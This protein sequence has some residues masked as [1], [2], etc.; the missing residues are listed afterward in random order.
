M[1]DEEIKK[2]LAKAA[3]ADAVKPKVHR[4]H[5]AVTYKK[6]PKLGSTK[7][8]FKEDA[9][10]K[11][12]I[13]GYPV[14]GLDKIASPIPKRSRYGRLMKGA[15]SLHSMSRCV[16]PPLAQMPE[17]MVEENPDLIVSGRRVCAL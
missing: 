13:T 1:K 10:E 4:M 12:E 9:R 6:L 7:P 11:R 5:R 2:M 3:P 16:S 14:P 8:V 17:E 15:L